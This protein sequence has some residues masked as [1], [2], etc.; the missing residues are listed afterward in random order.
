MIK[1]T[2]VKKSYNQRH[3]LININYEFPRTGLYIIYG[4]SGSGKTTLL[5]CL[6][7]LISF[8]GSIDIDHQT[9]ESLS[10]NELSDLRL[11]C[12]GFVFQDFKLFENE[13]VIANLLFP[14][15]TL[16]HLANSI[17]LQKCRDLL[18]L[19]GLE[20]KE[21]QIV[22]KLSG[23]EKQRVAIA[24]ALV[25]DPKVVLADE[26]T[27]ALD[28]KNGKEIMTILKSISKSALVIVVSHDRDLTRQYAD[29]IIEMEDGQIKEVFSRTSFTSPKE[30]DF[31]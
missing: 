22:N 8:E 21:K 20:K 10:D 31:K 26:P 5:N 30:Q 17:K 23:G 12:Y 13:T 28:E 18:A 7:G 29:T 16:N 9:I 25:N 27:G 4:P 14:L 2:N 11:T 15:E 6:S 3:A 24:R 1:L 19:V